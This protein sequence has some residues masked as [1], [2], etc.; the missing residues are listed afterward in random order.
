M[1]WHHLPADEVIE[2]TGS[3]TNG[4]DSDSAALKLAESGPNELQEKKK[5]PAWVLFLQQL[6]LRALQAIL[7]IPLSLW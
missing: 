6:S 2:L 5:K 1:N 3:S 4:L 7:Q